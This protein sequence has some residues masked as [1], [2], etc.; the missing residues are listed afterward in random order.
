MR[1]AGPALSLLF[2]TLAIPEFGASQSAARLSEPDRVR[3]A[4]AFRLADRVRAEV[5]P[6]WERTPMAVLLVADSAE[7]LVGH[8]RPT[9]D[10]TSLGRGALL[11]RDVLVRPRRFSPTL[12]ATFP[13]VGGRS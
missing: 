2:A 8:L 5:W 6:G 7:Y 9:S 13:A 4:E 11:G 10:F 1:P 3:L 12:L